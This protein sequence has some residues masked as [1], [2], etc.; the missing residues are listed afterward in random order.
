MTGIV[1]A[2]IS[3]HLP[4]WV[5]LCSIFSTVVAAPTLLGSALYYYRKGQLI[6]AIRRE[7]LICALGAVL[8]ALVAIFGLYHASNS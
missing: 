3:R 4:G 6:G 1:Y 7:V 2:L 5:L 8:F